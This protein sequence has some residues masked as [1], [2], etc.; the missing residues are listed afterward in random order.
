MIDTV[1]S[2]KVCYDISYRSEMASRRLSYC[3]RAPVIS[4]Q[5]FANSSVHLPLCTIQTMLELLFK[6]IVHHVRLLNVPGILYCINDQPG[7]SALIVI[8]HRC[9]KRDRRDSA[10]S[11][12]WREGSDHA[13]QI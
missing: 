10:T 12:S 4:R 6:H 8:D 3:V 9:G 7:Q 11:V 5:S 2:Q 1:A 13:L